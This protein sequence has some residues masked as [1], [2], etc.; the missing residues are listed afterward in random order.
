[1]VP[2][3]TLTVVSTET[4]RT[5]AIPQDPADR[6]VRRRRAVRVIAVGPEDRVLLF[7]V[8]SEGVA[9]VPQTL[10]EFGDAA[11]EAGGLAPPC[12]ERHR[13]RGEGEQGK[14]EPHG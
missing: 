12:D 4:G 2:V 6:P 1:M 14:R 9:R 3:R 10:I 11:L 13:E 5:F 8:A 7:E